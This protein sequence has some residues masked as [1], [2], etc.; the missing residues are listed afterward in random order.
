M[1]TE[2]QRF[3]LFLNKVP[4]GLEELEGGFSFLITVIM[5]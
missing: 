2:R 1:L 3:V 4:L 5:P